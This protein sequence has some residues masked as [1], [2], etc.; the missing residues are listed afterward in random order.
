MKNFIKALLVVMALVLV[1]SAFASCERECQHAGGTA[2]C[3]EAAVCEICGESYGEALNH[4]LQVTETVN[5]TYHLDGY[6]KSEC[7]N[8]CGLTETTVLPVLVAT[9]PEVVVTPVENDDLT[10]ALNFA[11]KDIENLSDDYLDALIET[12]GKHYVDYVLTIEGLTSENVTF[13]ADG[14]AD[15]YL[16]GQYDEWSANWISVP[17]ETVTVNNGDSL[18]IMEYAAKLMGKAGLRM[19]LEEIATIVI[20]FDC[21][22]YFTPEFLAANPDM[23]VTLQLIVFTE[24]AEGNKTLVDGA[25]VAENVFTVSTAD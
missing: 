1:V 6:V 7:A 11:I 24:D 2:T 16:A 14:T 25:P 8:G 20:N 10:F 21:G 9:L 12:Y 19:T 15:G 3:T 22:V 4:N 18:Y 17:F 5:P 23:V 13:N